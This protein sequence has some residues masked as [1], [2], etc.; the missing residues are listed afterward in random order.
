[1]TADYLRVCIVTGGSNGI[2]RA[3]SVA[4]A[5]RN[6][7]VIVVGRTQSHIDETLAAMAQAQP[8]GASVDHL[9]LALDVSSPSDMKWLSEV[10]VDRYRR[11]DVLIAS[12][13][14]G[15][16]SDTLSRLPKPT[17]QL[18]I[19]E[20]QSVINVN[21]HGIY[22]SNMAVLPL[23][24]AQGGG[25]IL[26]ICSST[27]PR[28]LRGR[29]MAQAYS[30]SKF[31]VAAYTEALANEVEDSGVRVSAVFPGPVRTSLIESTALHGPFGGWMETDSFAQQILGLLDLQRESRVAK[32][33]MLPVP[34]SR[35]SGRR[36]EQSL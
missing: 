31:A 28:G 26:N 12:A 2:G 5:Q 16:A 24:L 10:C 19:S 6:Y 18:T 22:L 15:R 30:A 25:D 35:A 14:I 1:M 11:V 8:A 7:A 23:M 9:G 36:A 27:T 34:K 13:G 4:L 17:T 3:V 29:P 21:L 32:P 20:W 33:H